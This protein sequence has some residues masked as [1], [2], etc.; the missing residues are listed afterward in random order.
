MQNRWPLYVLLGAGGA[1]ALVRAYT[2]Q[3]RQRQLRS[4]EIRELRSLWW[5]INGQHTHARVALDPARTATLPLVLVHGLG[6]SGSYFVPA[7]ERLATEFNVYV[8]D[9][10]G[11]GL[12]DTPC[13]Q[14]DIPGLAQE[15]V[16]WMDA[17]GLARV[18]LVSH[19][20]GCQVAIE[21]ALRYPER[22]DRLVLIAPVPDPAAR[23]AFQQV[24]RLAMG[25]FFE[26]PSLI[27]LVFKDYLRI[28]SRFFPEFRHMLA[29][30]MEAKLPE[31][32]VPV[33]LV[34]GE[35][36]AVAPQAWLEE[37]ATLSR[38][39]PAIVIPYWGHAVHYSGADQVTAAMRS[40]LAAEQSDVVRAA[41]SG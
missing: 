39:S 18:A 7:A 13:V 14:P 6:V 19:S 26:R 30:P 11:H 41:R 9:L 38:A 5:T 21:V 35:H 32:E 1:L 31:I 10:P 24:G 37:A 16:N 8:P 29:Y 3:R 27:M 36:D 15:L 17:A 20:M 34:R 40:F 25:S 12:S 23:K 33:M 28:G 22:I 4:G 2:Q